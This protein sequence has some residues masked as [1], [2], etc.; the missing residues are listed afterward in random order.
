MLLECPLL[1]LWESGEESAIVIDGEVDDWK[2]YSQTEQEQNNVDSA[3]IDIV[4]TGAVSDSIYLSLLTTTE[5]P[6]FASAEGKT[7]RILIDSDN[8]VDT[9]YAI[10]GMGADQMVEMYG[11]EQAVLSSI[12]YSFDNNK[13]S[14][15]WNGFFALSSVNSRTKRVNTEVQVPLFDLGAKASDEMKI[16]W[17]TTDNNEMVDLADNV[18][19]L[20]G[21]GFS[22]SSAIESRDKRLTVTT[23]EKAS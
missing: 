5:E 1:I 15:D 11:K 4:R 12:L 2:G 9:G 7:I 13:D 20:N 18:V 14:N 17:Q 8:S 6:M 10:P 23:A 16:I 19:S 3:N 21:I 22:L